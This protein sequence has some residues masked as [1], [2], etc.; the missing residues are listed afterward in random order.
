[1]GDMQKQKKYKTTTIGISK[2]EVHVNDVGSPYLHK[3]H[4]VVIRVFNNTKVGRAIVLDQHLIDSLFHEDQIDSRQHNVCDKYLGMISKSG[5]FPAAP[6]LSERI[7]TGNNNS[8]PLP[9]SCILI[10][11]QKNIRELCGKSKERIFWRIM[12]DNPSKITL[13]ELEVIKDCAN[14]LLSYWYVSP[15]SPVSLFQQALTNPSQY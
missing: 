9:R 10:G 1:M 14:A 7:F 13:I 5:S 8:Q 12:V 6:Q 15:E 4:E 3:H 2:E 11:V